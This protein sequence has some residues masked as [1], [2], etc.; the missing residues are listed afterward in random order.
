MQQEER[1]STYVSLQGE[2]LEKC[3][4]QSTKVYK[5]TLEETR[6]TRQWVL[7]YENY[8]NLLWTKIK[9]HTALFL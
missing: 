6:I 4:H 9:L 3:F 8:T 7:F 5:E 2:L 1:F